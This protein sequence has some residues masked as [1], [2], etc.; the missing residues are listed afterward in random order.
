[1]RT[2]SPAPQRVLRIRLLAHA[3]AMQR[4]RASGATP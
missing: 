2:A 4:G 3:L 1:M